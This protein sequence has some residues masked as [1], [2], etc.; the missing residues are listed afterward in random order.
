MRVGGLVERGV[1]TS[2]TSWIY[3][4][5]PIV[6]STQTLSLTLD[7]YSHFGQRVNVNQANS[8]RI[9]PASWAVPVIETLR[10]RKPV[11]RRI[12]GIGRLHFD[13]RLPF[14]CVYQTPSRR[15][16][17]GAGSLV[18]TEANFLL[19]EPGPG[20]REEAALFFKQL[21]EAEVIEASAFFILMVS[22][23]PML[24]HGD[25]EI[26]G[27]LF[28]PRFHIRWVQSMNAA[29]DPVQVL[30]GELGKIRIHR[31]LARVDDTPYRGIKA[32]HLPGFISIRDLKALSCIPVSL[33]I[34]PFFREAGT[35]KIYPGVLRQLRHGLSRAFKRA[36]FAFAQS[37]AKSVPASFLA[38]GRRAL[39]RTVFEIDASLADLSGSFD[40]LLQATPVNVERCWYQFSRSRSQRPPEFLYRPLPIDP[41]A[42]KRDLFSIRID[43]IEDPSLQSL[44]RQTQLDLDRQL[45]MLLD[46]NTARFKYGSLQVYGKIDKALVQV[47]ETVLAV[48]TCQPAARRE[49]RVDA[50]A[51]ATMS[52]NLVAQYREGFPGFEAQVRVSDELYSGLLVSRGTLLVG[53]HT[54]IPR[55][56]IQAMLG[57]EVST[58]LLTYF[59]GKSQRLK[60]LAL[61]LSGYD[62]L[63]EG[64][65]VLAEYL[66][67]ELSQERLRLLAARVVAVRLMVDGADF[68]DTFRVLTE[69]YGF[70]PKAAFT[71]TMRVF[72]AGGLTKDAEYL[73]GLQQVLAFVAD[74]GTLA[75]LY[76]GKISVKHV[77][78]MEEL[79]MRGIL[80]PPPLL[81]DFLNHAAALER[82]A[83]LRAE[84]TLESLMPSKAMA[85]KNKQA[86]ASDA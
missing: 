67:G 13:R 12:P 10:A 80:K 15:T 82:L 16:D 84:P 73:R 11:R 46:R 40:F 66:V 3:S 85:K 34:S 28:R 76:V 27:Q 57:H 86:E 62:A 8:D 1:C 52:R 58:H 65:A 35:Q 83:R 45:T 69:K 2:A 7:G 68:M 21:V 56:R 53:K 60:L 79:A 71:I 9:A 48:S 22:T 63:Q 55:N 61:G 4:I 44:M 38:L 23:A 25:Q 77:A 20:P 18:T 26:P 59:N 37:Q 29:R 31:R 19:L 72:R 5:R 14:M 81:P 74:G 6:A 70:R 75:P 43:A 39:D 36:F 64:L 33:E 47:A 51:F 24:R 49:R 42:M 78:I 50:Q 41:L 32:L 54:R 17:P 30:C